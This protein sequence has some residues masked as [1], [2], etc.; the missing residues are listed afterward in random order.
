M[1]LLSCK[2]LLT[3]LNKK[4]VTIPLITITTYLSYGH[5][6]YVD[7]AYKILDESEWMYNE[8]QTHF[9]SKFEE[10]KTPLY[11]NLDRNNLFPDERYYEEVRKIIK[12][13]T[14]DEEYRALF[15][16]TYK[17]KINLFETLN[18][19]NVKGFL[20]FRPFLNTCELIDITKKYKMYHLTTDKNGRPT[21]LVEY[22]YNNK[23][24]AFSFSQHE[25]YKELHYYLQHSYDLLD[26]SQ[27]ERFISNGNGYAPPAH[28]I[29]ALADYYDKGE[30]VRQDKKKAKEYFGLAC[31]KKDT[32]ACKKYAELN[33]QG[34]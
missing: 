11:Y 30:E 4:L 9:E 23:M 20:L 1:T 28:Y 7:R 17:E 22:P 3:L 21:T 27:I 15:D 18:G 14:E 2:K 6:T 34:F 31:D 26:F 8:L 32:E 29:K 24:I 33:E 5:Y 25:C 13:V 19:F 10:Y 12:K 16:K